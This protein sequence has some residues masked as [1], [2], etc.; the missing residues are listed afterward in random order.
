MGFGNTVKGSEPRLIFVA[1]IAALSAFLG[2]L[3][4]LVG[5]LLFGAYPELSQTANYSSAVQFLYNWQTLTGAL[6]ALF[7]ASITF[8][9]I[10][11][12]TRS[13][14]KT[15]SDER[16]AAQRVAN[17]A[18]P[19]ALSETIKY[20]AE[21]WKILNELAQ[22][23]RL[24]DQI[25]PRTIE[26]PK[27]NAEALAQIR[28]IARYPEAG[29]EHIIDLIVALS[30]KIQYH[31]ARLRSFKSGEWRMDKD[32]LGALLETVAEI[33]AILSDLFSYF[34][35]SY[36]DWVVTEERIMLEARSFPPEGKLSPGYALLKEFIERR[37]KLAEGLKSKNEPKN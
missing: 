10:R 6:I 3:T 36:V 17:A 29:N 12:Q 4:A 37:K 14:T 35:T 24:T 26:F 5:M 16:I 34:S 13:N 15:T 7:A 25:K 31:E 1:T 11:E 18:L 23:M 30:R 21:H 20:T 33:K 32:F 19:A 2:G 28:E 22:T 8:W 9:A 27:P